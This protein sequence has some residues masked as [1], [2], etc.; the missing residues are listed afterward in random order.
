MRTVRPSPPEDLT[1]RALIRDAAIV[2][3]AQ[4]GF[5]KSSLRAIAATAGVSASLVVHHFGSKE[6]LRGECDEFV[7]GTMLAAARDKAS[8]AGLQAVIQ[9]YLANPA[10]YEVDVAYLSRAIAEETTAGRTFVD[11]IVDETEAIIRAGIADGTMN[12]SSDPRAVAVLI[13]TT[14]LAMMTMSAHLARS[15]GFEGL[16]LGQETMRRLA[17]PSV[18]LYTHG[19]YTDETVLNVTRKALAATPEPAAA[20]P[21]EPMPAQEYPSREDTR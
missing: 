15:L 6:R 5:R 21:A 19:L 12:P 11:T 8:P 14:S 10:E 1:A 18:E 4:D 13:A 7:I 20:P 16:G 9:G 2:H 17:L 3:F